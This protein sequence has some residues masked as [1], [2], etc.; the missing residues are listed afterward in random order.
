[1]EKQKLDRIMEMIQSNETL[2][3]QYQE[4]PDETVN[5]MISWLDA[6]EKG[7]D[8]DPYFSRRQAMEFTIEKLKKDLEI[9]REKGNIAEAELIAREIEISSDM[10]SIVGREPDFPEKVRQ[11]RQKQ[12]CL[13]EDREALNQAKLQNNNVQ[14]YTKNT[15]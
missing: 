3:M 14:K 15:L 5:L 4:N 13:S 11:I 1:M 8:L 10:L 12:I 2:K 7:I 6:E 9:C